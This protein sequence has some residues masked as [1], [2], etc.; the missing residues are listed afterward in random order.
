MKIADVYAERS[1]EYYKQENSVE[2][3]FITADEYSPQEL[4]TMEKQILKVIGCQLNRPTSMRF[5]K[6]YCEALGVP[7]Q[8]RELSKFLVDMML[9]S[10]GAVGFKSSLLASACLFI[11][12]TSKEWKPE[13]EASQHAKHLLKPAAFQSQFAAAV[14]FVLRTWRDIRTAVMYAQFESIYTK[15]IDRLGTDARMLLPPVVTPE[16]IAKWL[17]GKPVP[18]TMDIE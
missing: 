15:Y 10:Y 3:A 11:A 16:D 7:E 12:T 9:M 18:T 8:V 13:Q 1:K 14:K 6:L 2:Y 4:V 5:V 17:D